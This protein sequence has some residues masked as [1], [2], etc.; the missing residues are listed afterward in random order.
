MDQA[1]S[2]PIAAS[3]QIWIDTGGTFTDCI[4]VGPDGRLHRVKVLSSHILRSRVRRIES[5]TALAVEADWAANPAVVGMRAAFADDRRLTVVG[6]GVGRL[7]FD[8][9]LPNIEQDATIELSA[10]EEAP[11]L[12][13]RLLTRMPVGQPL[14]RIHMRLAT[15]RGTN[16]LLERKGAPTALFI[17]EGFGDLLRIGDQ[18]RPDLFALD[19]RKPAPL[20]GPVVEV[21]GRL[22]AHGQVVRPLDLEA[23]RARAESLAR[24]GVRCAAVVLMHSWTNPEHEQ[25]IKT[26]LQEVGFEHISCSRRSRWC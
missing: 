24:D 14:P 12:G 3:W 10:D 11:I 8:R 9:P 15:T 2:Q 20:H 16:A 13:A 17:T 7:V 26:V 21:A 18:T 1:R 25:R 22:D 5:E 4:G 6:H 19:I 23:V